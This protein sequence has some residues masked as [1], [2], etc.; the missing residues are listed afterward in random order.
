M[1]R[2]PHIRVSLELVHRDVDAWV[3]KLQEIFATGFRKGQQL[4]DRHVSQH[5]R[6]S[7]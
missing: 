6:I 1:V 5:Y 2:H 4:E 3:C 7:E